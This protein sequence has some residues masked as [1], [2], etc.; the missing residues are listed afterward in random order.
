MSFHFIFVTNFIRDRSPLYGMYVT[1]YGNVKY[2]VPIPI[3]G[4]S[5]KKYLSG[6]GFEPTPTYVDCNLNA[7]P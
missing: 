7:A 1:M 2:K 4:K 5:K 6:M 3:V